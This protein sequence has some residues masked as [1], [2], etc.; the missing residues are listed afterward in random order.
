[1]KSD[2][3]ANL[4]RSWAILGRLRANVS[5]QIRGMFGKIAGTGAGLVDLF[6][7]E[8]S[9][10]RHAPC[11]RTRGGGLKTPTA[12]DRRPVFPGSWA[13]VEEE[14]RGK[15]E[16]QTPPKTNVKSMFLKS[17]ADLEESR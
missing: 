13:A 2:L 4:R 10:R 3:G 15:V 12:I 14:R 5:K 17:S 9:L 8:L 16:K 11:L 6:D 1:M 7:F